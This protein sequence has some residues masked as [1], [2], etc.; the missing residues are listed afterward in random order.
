MK[1]NTSLETE[2]ERYKDM[3]CVKEA[4]F[5]CAKAYGL[6]EEH[7][8]KSEKS[9]D[10][11]ELKV[12]DFKQKLSKMEKQL[13]EHQSIISTLSSKKEELEKFYKE[14]EDNDIKKSLVWKNNF[15]KPQY[16]KKAQS[17][18]PCLYDLACNKNVLAN[19]FAR[20]S[21]ETIRSWI[22]PDRHTVRRV[23][24]LQLSPT[25]EHTAKH[26]ANF[27]QTLKEEMVED[28]RYFNSLEKEV[29]SLYS[30][31]ELQRTQFSN[32]N[33]RILVEC[34]YNDHMCAILRS[35]DVDPFV[36][37]VCELG[38][39]TYQCKRL[40]TKLSKRHKHESEKD[41]AKLE[42]H[43]INLELALQNKM[44]RMILQDKTIEI[45]GVRERLNK[46]NGKFMVT[47]FEKPSVVR[48]LN[49]FKLQKALVS[50]KP[51]PFT[52][53][54]EKQDFLKP[55]SRSVL[56]T[57]VKQD[58]SKLV[59]PHILPEKEKGNQVHRNTNVLAP[60][61]FKLDTRLTQTRTPQLPQENM[62]TNQGVSIFTVLNHTTSVK[63]TGMKDRVLPNDN[64]K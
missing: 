16:L 60:E 43:C 9:L 2:L 58:L 21:D 1:A 63:S 45:N 17:A 28:M 18:K 31:L 12:H 35:Y 52:H 13:Y 32:E 20:N 47:E 3:K 15:A 7:K 23:L 54:L 42:K 5:E 44:K 10:S 51:T 26:V 30:Q 29:E 4:E 59:T 24:E 53:S 11:Y 56:R 64:I 57:N 38:E 41:F 8:I 33:N 14:R 55:R 19:K 34:Y 6:L 37:V 36:D 40:E 25:V 27:K 22:V 50:G 48:Q 62:R 39:K 49:A 46:L 61:M